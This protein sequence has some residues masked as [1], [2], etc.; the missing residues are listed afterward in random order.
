MRLLKYRKTPGWL[1]KSISVLES[2][3][4][5]WLEYLHGV[6]YSRYVV[7]RSPRPKIYGKVS[8][9]I[10]F[11]LKVI[12]L[13]SL[14][15]RKP[16]KCRVL[17]FSGTKNQTTAL[18]PTV[19]A[20]LKAGASVDFLHLGRRARSNKVCNCVPVQFSLNDISKFLIL[21]F[22]RRQDLRVQLDPRPA[23][24]HKALDLFLLVYIFLPYFE[25][26]LRD[27][28]P[29]LVLV[30]ND[31][32]APNRII[33]AMA[34]SMGIKTAYLQHAS[35][36]NLFPALNF[37]LSFL[38]GRK[39]LEIYKKCEESHPKTAKRLQSRKVYL[40]GQKRPLIKSSPQN[41]SIGIALGANTEWEMVEELV[42]NLQRRGDPVVLRW[43]PRSQ[44][45]VIKK[46]KRRF[47]AF[48]AISDPKNETLDQFLKRIK[49]LVGGNSNI[50][51]E[52][53]LSRVS[54]IYF[55]FEKLGDF[56]YYG[57]VSEGIA[58]PAD[59]IDKVLYLTSPNRKNSIEFN[60]KSLQYY[61]ATVGTEWEGREGEVC[62]NTI[63]G[64]LDGDSPSTYFGYY[65]EVMD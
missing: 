26:V 43:H 20:L 25:K 7:S 61:S 60:S 32:S 52:A 41:R 39:A 3:P 31:H 47:E 62:A 46:V 50:L 45:G 16:S 30:S 14:L 44:F 53:A 63:C 48:A 9:I 27:C 17:V 40:N 13:I 24:Y 23:I 55:D 33:V 22:W 19:T 15:P 56:D 12:P 2:S 42:E 21:Y 49:F 54:P 35:V 38:D 51:L 28:R 29:E 10:V 1:K 64:I 59:T 8:R 65:G 36:S 37:S 5:V 11:A 6:H 58:E 4:E 57:F 34:N 18:Q